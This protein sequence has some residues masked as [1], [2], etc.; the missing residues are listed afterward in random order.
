MSKRAL[1]IGVNEYAIP[2]ANLRGCVN[3]VHNIAG[4]LPELYGFA[5]SDI[6]MLLDDAATKARIARCTCPAT[7]TVLR[8]GPSMT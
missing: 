5:E 7:G 1:L 2:G 3:D 6:T 8:P 4:A